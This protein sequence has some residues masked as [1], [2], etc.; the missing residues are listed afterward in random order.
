MLLTAVF[1]EI[2]VYK[3]K[4]EKYWAWV[5]AIILSGFNIAS[6]YCLLGIISMAGLVNKEVARVYVK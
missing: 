4:Q 1:T 6:I 5:A 2:V 3:L